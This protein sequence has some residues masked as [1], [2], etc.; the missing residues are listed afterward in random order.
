MPS[1]L[2]VPRLYACLINAMMLGTQAREAPNRKSGNHTRASRFATFCWCLRLL[3]TA[4]L[5]TRFPTHKPQVK[6]LHTHQAR[7][8]YQQYPGPSTI[9]RTGSLQFSSVVNNCLVS[10]VLLF[11]RTYLNNIW[12]KEQGIQRLFLEGTNISKILTNTFCCSW[13][14]SSVFAGT[15]LYH[16]NMSALRTCCPGWQQAAQKR[17]W[18][19]RKKP[20]CLFPFPAQPLSLDKKGIWFQVPP[21]PPPILFWR[22]PAHF[23]LQASPTLIWLQSLQTPRINITCFK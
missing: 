9:P 21:Q 20:A 10:L 6:K 7:T 1:L 5:G 14:N 17:K 4:T 15:A 19:C 16:K 22:I 12:C 11:P 23:F 3:N 13:I 18:K 2:K 8:Y